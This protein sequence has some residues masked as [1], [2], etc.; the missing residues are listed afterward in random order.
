MK[1]SQC[2]IDTT[3]GCSHETCPHRE[4]WLSIV[5][6]SNTPAPQKEHKT[7]QKSKNK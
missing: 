4:V 7:K 2:G 6:S 1:C 5:G 3:T